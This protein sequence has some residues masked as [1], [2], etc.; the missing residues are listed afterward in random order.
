[1]VEENKNFYLFTI[2]KYNIREANRSLFNNFFSS[3]LF[4]T[5]SSDLVG[6][7]YGAIE[8]QF[9]DR[10]ES[11]FRA[12]QQAMNADDPSVAKEIYDNAMPNGGVFSDFFEKRHHYMYMLQATWKKLLEEHLKMLE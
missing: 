11:E 10:I 1:M 7:T 3:D 12:Y 5:L 8:R 4:T 2:R 9:N 6:D